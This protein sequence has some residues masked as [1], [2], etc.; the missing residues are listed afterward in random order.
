M[1]PHWVTSSVLENEF[2]LQILGFSLGSQWVGHDYLAKTY[3]GY[4]MMNT[5]VFVSLRP[6]G[7]GLPLAWTMVKKPKLFLC[8]SIPS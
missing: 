1:T 7:I 2:V 6:I 5:I 3:V 4:D 8:V